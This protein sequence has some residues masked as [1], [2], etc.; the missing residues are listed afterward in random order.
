MASN[1]AWLTFQDLGGLA[2]D[3]TNAQS[4]QEAP[5]RSRPTRIDPIE[6]VLSAFVAHPLQRRQILL[7]QSV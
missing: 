1:C 2:A 7:R 6:H 5:Q 3:V 4:R